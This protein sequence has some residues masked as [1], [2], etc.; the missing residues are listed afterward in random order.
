MKT[1]AL[2]AIDHVA[3]FAQSAGAVSTAMGLPPAARG[4][5]AD[6]QPDGDLGNR[7]FADDS[8]PQTQLQTQFP[9][10]R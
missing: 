3:E 2:A 1:A 6:E 8:T 5:A 4:E 7:E 9:R 10:P